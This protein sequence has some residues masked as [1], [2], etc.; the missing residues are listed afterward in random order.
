[1]GGRQL[2]QS[3]TRVLLAGLLLACAESAPPLTAP[4]TMV[5]LPGDDNQF[6]AYDLRQAG[7]GP[8]DWPV[9]FVFRG[10]ATVERIQNGLCSETQHPWKYCDHGGSMYLFARGG[11]A[12]EPFSGY[13]ADG[14]LKRFGETCATNDFT[15]HLRIYAPAA[16]SFTSPTYGHIVVATAHL[17][18]QDKAGCSGRV[19]G[20]SDVA[21]AWFIE[22]MRTIPGWEVNADQVDLGNANEQFVVMRDVS[23]ADVPHIYQS[24]RLATEVIIT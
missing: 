16:D 22:A 8:V 1:M 20:Y 2:A 6:G 19:H 15:A 23:G 3:S 17:D 18:F 7:S 21:E 5:H 13:I 24:D 4:V 9:T 11:T 12:G 14:G 10:N